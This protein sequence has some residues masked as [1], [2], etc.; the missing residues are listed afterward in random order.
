MESFISFN[1]VKICSET[2][3]NPGEE[4]VKNIPGSKLI[5]LEGRGHELHYL[6]W[7]IVIKA[8]IEFTRIPQKRFD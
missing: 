1:G 5:I 8:I 7:D 2:F 4:I 3:G 6:D